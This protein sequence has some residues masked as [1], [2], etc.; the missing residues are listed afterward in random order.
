MSPALTSYSVNQVELFDDVFVRVAAMIELSRADCA[1]K[2]IAKV[3]RASTISRI[4]ASDDAI[5]VARP[6]SNSPAFD[7][8]TLVATARTK[9]QQ[10]LLAISRRNSLDE[11]VTDV[12]VERGDKPVVLSTATNPAARFSDNRLQDPGQRS[13]GDDELTTCVALRP[14]IP[15]QHLVR[16]LVRASHVVQLKL[17]AANPSME[18]RFSPPSPKPRP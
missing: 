18:S 8:E 7:F 14:D 4:L 9:S 17:E 1:G 3:P 15:R 2:S 5:D 10:H 13:D 12:L 16:L 6:C 11:V